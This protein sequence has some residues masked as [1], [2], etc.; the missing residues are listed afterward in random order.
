MDDTQFSF[1]LL[2][3]LLLS[4][5]RIQWTYLDTW[6]WYVLISRRFSSFYNLIFDISYTEKKGKKKH[7][8]K[9]VINRSNI[10]CTFLY[11][12]LKIWKIIPTYGNL[13]YIK[14]KIEPWYFSFREGWY[15]ISS[16]WRGKISDW[17]L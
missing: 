11:I 1:I 13:V 14:I 9:L 4:T 5:S 15:T 16:Y 7:K 17:S 6:S 10:I 2:A 3:Y 8:K 12:D